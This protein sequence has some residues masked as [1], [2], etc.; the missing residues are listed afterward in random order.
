L[1]G[2]LSQGRRSN[3]N[4]LFWFL[5]VGLLALLVVPVNLVQY[6][7]AARLASAI[8]SAR[9]QLAIISKQLSLMQFERSQETKAWEVERRERA[10]QRARD[11]ED[12]KDAEERAKMH[13]NWDSPAYAPHCAA[14]GAREYT[15][16]LNN[17]KEGYDLKKACERTLVVIH[18]NVVNKPDWCEMR[19]G[20]MVVMTRNGDAC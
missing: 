3:S 19:V 20:T 17:V 16:K 1:I 8:S 15:S 10:E 11:D 12:K 4:R 18:E 2:T 6:M 5:I 14:W 13:L 9:S 7:E